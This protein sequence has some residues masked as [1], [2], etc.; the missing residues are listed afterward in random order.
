ML[1]H[2]VGARLARSPAQPRTWRSRA[3]PPSSCPHVTGDEVRPYHEEAEGLRLA[4]S[5]SCGALDVVRHRHLVD[6][7]YVMGVPIA[8]ACALARP[9]VRV[10]LKLALITGRGGARCFAGPLLRELPW[11]CQGPWRSQ[12]SSQLGGRL[13]P[14]ERAAFSEACQDGP[15]NWCP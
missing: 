10:S 11:L 9:C 7:S 4:R 13:L 5:C 15:P 12:V 6:V 14:E 8:S 1:S 3:L 2:G